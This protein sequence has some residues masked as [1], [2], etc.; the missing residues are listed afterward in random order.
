MNSLERV[1]TTLSHKEPDRVPWFNLA[2]MHGAKELNMSIE[3]YF[4]KSDNVIRGQEILHKKYGGDCLYPFYYASIETRAWGGEVIF[5]DNGPP[6]SGRPL[7]DSIDD[8]VSLEPP[9]PQDDIHLKKV[10]ETEK[11]LSERYGDTIP[12]IGVAISP[13]SIPVMQLGFSRYLDVIFEHEDVFWDLMS[14]SEKS[15]LKI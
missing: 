6:I 11:M 13:F 4:S 7:V 5:H 1:L 12:I 10:L 15:I 2:T 14:T 3:Q 8:I 9:T